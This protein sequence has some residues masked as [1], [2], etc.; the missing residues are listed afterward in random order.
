ME[1]KPFP[2]IARFNRECIITEKIDGT[3]A[4]IFIEA[5][6]GI[7]LYLADESPVA[8]R[9]YEGVIYRIFAGSRSMW[10]Q[11]NQK[12]KDNYGFAQWVTDNA[13]DLIK[14]GPGRHY[15]EWYGRGIQRTYGLDHK[16]F[17]LFDAVRWQGSPDLPKCCHVVP[18][19]GMY[20][21][22]P[23]PDY[24]NGW[25]DELRMSGS[26]LATWPAEGIVI[27]HR[28]GN[29]AYKVTLENDEGGKG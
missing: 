25:V 9:E 13:D 26:R 3:N 15:G 14:L 1:F 2:K 22:I 24:V 4:Q 27:Y 20:D 6:E 5:F 29:H 23:G 18:V 16:R 19:L 10:L 21:R 8:W 11:T 17:A 28:Q 12:N 7:E